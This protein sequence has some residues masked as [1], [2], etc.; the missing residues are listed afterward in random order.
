MRAAGTPR[1]V[2]HGRHTIHNDMRRSEH[3]ILTTH[4][5]SLIRPAD[6][7]R[8][9]QARQAGEPV[10]EPAYEAA[11]RAA[12]SEV[13]RRQRDA[14]VDIVDDGEFSKAS[15]G[16]YINSRVSGFQR[17]PNRQLAINYFGHDVERF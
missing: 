6:T 17:D 8:F 7:S 5:G 10:D 12:V 3:G 14:G 9:D 1:P 11:L 4:V 2:P 16:T 13:V 15:W